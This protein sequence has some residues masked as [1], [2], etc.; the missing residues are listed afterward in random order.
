MMRA[1]VPSPGLPVLLTFQ[2]SSVHSQTLPWTLPPWVGLD[3][4]H[5]AT[6]VAARS[7]AA[8]APGATSPQNLRSA[9]RYGSKTDLR[10]HQVGFRLARTLA[11]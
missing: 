3:A 9:S 2:Q 4:N 6:A 8:A 10:G 11:P 1:M 7:C 5:P